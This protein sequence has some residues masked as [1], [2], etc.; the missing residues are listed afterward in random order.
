M[1]PPNSMNAISRNRLSTPSERCT[2]KGRESVSAALAIFCIVFLITWV[3]VGRARAADKS[4]GFVI[5]VSN[6]FINP[7]RVE[8]IADIQSTAKEYQ[9]KG[10]IKDVI[11]ASSNTDVQGQI[12]QIRNLMS[13]GV[14]GIL[15]NAAS[16]TALNSVLKEAMDAGIKVV[17]WDNEVALRGVYSVVYDQED[18]ARQSAEWLA[19]SLNGKGNVIIVNGIA[20]APVSEVRRAAV[21]AVFD[22]NPGIKVL[23]SVYGDWDVAKAQQVMA[24]VVASQPNI[25]GVWV[26]GAMSEGVLR[27]LLAPNPTKLPIVVGDVSL[28]YLRLW[29]STKQKYPD[30]RSFA[31]G[32]SPCPFAAGGLRVLV[33]ILQGKQPTKVSK[34]GD[35][36]RISVS[37]PLNVDDNN[38]EETLS[39]NIDKADTFY[40]DICPSADEIETNLK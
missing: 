2:Q 27:A 14:D 36:S 39:K 4:G 19:K 37:F 12:A 25:D 23:N 3:V 17:A 9:A 13:K 28:G 5:G 10:A 11:V 8:Q 40:L 26:C 20:G 29:K 34:N 6:A 24:S 18:W 1:I 32:D 38:L 31:V 15:I 22:K 16:P 7:H 21:Q 33:N 35:V 30:Y